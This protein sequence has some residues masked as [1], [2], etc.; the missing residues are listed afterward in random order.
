MAA[1]L[2]APLATRDSAVTIETLEPDDVAALRLPGYRAART[3]RS[4]LERYPGRSV[5]SPMTLEYAQVG[6]WRNRSEIA[7]VDELVAVRNAEPLLRAAFER[8]VMHGDELLIAIE[9]ESQRAPSR[10][11]RA[12]LEPLEEVIT[13][14]TTIAQRRWTPRTPIRLVPVVA[15]DH[16][17]IDTIARLDAMA[18][19]WLWRNSRAE[20]DI[21]LDIPGV[22]VSLV[23]LAGEPVG[24]VGITHF[25]GWGHLDRIAVAPETQGRG[26]GRDA[27]EL[28]VEA[29]RRRGSR[30]VALST[31]RTNRRSQRLYERFG[32]R[33]TYD[34]DYRLFGRWRDPDGVIARETRAN[35]A[36]G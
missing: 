27:L 35:E 12:G 31:Q 19:P 20:F 6:S 8:C 15:G 5:W 32:F 34:H 17:A 10:F 30:R 9:L 22:E 29:M 25:A 23:E 11:E 18:F 4:A 1:A 3:L 2:A 16:R 36:H 13:Y 24:Y 7:N 14:D 33:R 26:L 28:A 21:Y